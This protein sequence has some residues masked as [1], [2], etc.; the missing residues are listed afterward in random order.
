MLCPKC[1]K[2][3]PAEAFT[4]ERGPASGVLLYVAGCRC[5]KALWRATRPLVA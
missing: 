1:G 3:V 2:T 5:G 4:A